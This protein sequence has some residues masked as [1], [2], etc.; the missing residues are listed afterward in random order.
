MLTEA[1]VK[2][3]SFEAID[4]KEHIRS[5]FSIF[6]CI[7]RQKS[8]FPPSDLLTGKRLKTARNKLIKPKKNK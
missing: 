7:K 4:A 1:S 3:I 6:L 5:A 2:T 8:A